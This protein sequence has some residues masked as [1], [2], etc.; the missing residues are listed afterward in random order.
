MKAGTQSDHL[1]ASP[2]AP[3]EADLGNHSVATMLYHGNTHVK[4]NPLKHAIP[5]YWVTRDA[6][7]PGLN[8]SV[9]YSFMLL[10]VVHILF[11]YSVLPKHKV[12]G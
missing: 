2:G 8:I 11:Y 5:I 10:S 6:S 7:E 9:Q 3:R 1:S 4:P 12:T